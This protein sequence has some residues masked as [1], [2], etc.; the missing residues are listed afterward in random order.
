MGKQISLNKIIYKTTDFVPAEHQEYSYTVF[1]LRWCMKELAKQILEL[2]A[3]N[4]ESNIEIYSDDIDNKL[5]NDVEYS[6]I[7]DKKSILNTIEQIKP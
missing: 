1:E 7:V 6:I 4:A 2:A 5:F 3:E